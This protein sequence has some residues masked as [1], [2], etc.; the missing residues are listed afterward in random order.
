VTVATGMGLLASTFTRSQIAAMFTTMIG[1]IMPT[2]QFS[3]MLDPT[4]SLEGAARFIG[5][6]YPAAHML[7][8]SRG[9]FN[10]GL[11]MAELQPFFWPL[12]IAVPVLLGASLALLRKQEV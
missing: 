3:G 10:K 2:V 11:G 12:L 7:T 9:V 1:T 8:I 4:S 5:K 6:V